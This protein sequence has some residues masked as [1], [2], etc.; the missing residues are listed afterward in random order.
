M[1]A[2]LDDLLFKW[3]NWKKSDRPNHPSQP[4]PPTKL[5]QLANFHNFCPILMKIGMDVV[6]GGKHLKWA[7]GVAGPIYGP[8]QL[9]YQP[10]QK[11]PQ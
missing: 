1:V 8:L 3:A 9:P 11:P 4:T 2:Y 5:M 6:F 10:A 7:D